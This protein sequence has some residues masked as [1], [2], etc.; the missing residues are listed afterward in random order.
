L[1]RQKLAGLF[2]DTF[3]YNA[4]TTASDALWSGLPVVTRIG[5]SFASRVAASLLTAVGLP[6]LI[7]HTIEEYESLVISLANNPEH[8]SAV[9]RKLKENIKTRRLF[10]MQEF[11]SEY[12]AILTQMYQYAVA[13]QAAQIID[14]ENLSS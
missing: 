14:V 6:E 8:L 11:M 5:N 13:G 1:G 2:L 12:E 7:T 10:N 4:H 3:P 9:R